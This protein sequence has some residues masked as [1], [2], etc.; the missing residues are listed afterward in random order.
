[1]LFYHQLA[2]HM[3]VIGLC[4]IPYDTNYVVILGK[5]LEHEDLI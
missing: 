3:I 5:L 2:N 1:M 4:V